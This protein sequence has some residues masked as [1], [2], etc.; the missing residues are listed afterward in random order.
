MLL[1]EFLGMEKLLLAVKIRW[2]HNIGLQKK[3]LQLHLKKSMVIR[4]AISAGLFPLFLK[5]DDIN[6]EKEFVSV[7]HQFETQTMFTYVLVSA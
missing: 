1:A 3:K 2:Y 5:Q 7:C 4:K 6:A